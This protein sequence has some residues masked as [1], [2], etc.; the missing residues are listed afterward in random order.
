MTTAERKKQLRTLI[1]STERTLSEEY[2]RS[3]SQAITQ[4]VK[5]MP[6][7]Q[8]ARSVFCFVGTKREIDTTEL[9][10]DI[11]NQ[12]KQL[13]VPLCTGDGIMELREISSL[14]QLSPGAY[15][16]LEPPE[17]SASVRLDE[18]ALSVIPCLSCDHQGR[19][20]GQGGGYYDRLFSHH[21]GQTVMLC[22]ERLMIAPIPTEPLDRTFPL[23][24]TERGIFRNLE[25]PPTDP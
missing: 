6:E 16:I 23:V 22:R 11:L 17:D 24:V 7:Y 5:G 9:L 8:S 21:T 2:R 18:V 15:G 14:S 4:F 12:G 13:C 10:R 20:L 3:S 19:R 25:H 1:R